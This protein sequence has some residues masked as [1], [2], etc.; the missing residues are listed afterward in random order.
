MTLG[1]LLLSLLS[2]QPPL[3]PDVPTTTTKHWCLPY[4]RW[5]FCILTP[6]FPSASFP[7]ADSEANPKNHRA[8][9]SMKTNG[10]QSVLCSGVPSL[11]S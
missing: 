10:N 9:F 11:S 1:Y 5:A 4:Q 2:V 3:D 8:N 7:T 6:A